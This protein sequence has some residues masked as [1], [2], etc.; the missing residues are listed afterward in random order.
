MLSTVPEHDFPYQ[1]FE[2]NGVHVLRGDE[3]TKMLTRPSV[4]AISQADGADTRRPCP[5]CG[6]GKRMHSF[7]GCTYTEV[8]GTECPC[9]VAYNDIP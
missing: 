1:D 9:T 8:D 6:H 4:N 2:T 3:L 7:K 5:N